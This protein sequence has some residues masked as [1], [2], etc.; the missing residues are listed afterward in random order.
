MKHIFL[1]P[2]R[3]RK[4]HLDYYLENTLPLLLKHLDDV[5]IVVIEQCNDKLFNR[6]I[7]LNIGFE[8]YKNEN[9]AIFYTHDVDLNP[10][11]EMIISNYK[12]EINDKEIISI[13]SDDKTLGGII[14]FNNNTFLKMNGFPNNFWGWGVEDKALQNRAEF[15]NI[16]IIRKN[17]YEDMKKNNK[18]KIFDDI[19]DRKLNTNFNDITS[20]E[21]YKFQNLSS[22]KKE[23]HTK[24]SGLN[25]LQ[26]IIL[27]NNK[28]NDYVNIIKVD[29]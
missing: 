27:N 22:E 28:L 6:G 3:N 5:K 9:N 26:Y 4:R 7:L 12:L 21:Y 2:Y 18:L 17:E 25:N 1:I 19:N 14:A 11:E 23:E 24:S 29:V 8:I 20:F 16:K 15:Y 13:Y 10:S